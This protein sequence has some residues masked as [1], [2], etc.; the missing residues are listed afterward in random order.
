MHKIDGDVCTLDAQCTNHSCGD[1]MP[2]SNDLLD[3]AIRD[4]IRRWIAQGAK[5]D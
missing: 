1:T 5:N 3:L 4:T 2:G